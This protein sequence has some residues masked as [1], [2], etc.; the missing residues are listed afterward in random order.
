MNSVKSDIVCVE[1]LY[2]HSDN[3]E[4]PVASG[5]V[6]VA[7]SG[8]AQPFGSEYKFDDFTPNSDGA[9]VWTASDVYSTYHFFRNPGSSV[10]DTLPSATSLIAEMADSSVGTAF[11]RKYT[12]GSEYDIT[13]VM[14]AGMTAQ[15]NELT[16]YAGN[17]RDIYFVVTS[18]TTMNVWIV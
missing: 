14:G 16:V 5:A 10:N 7:A 9:T 11:K 6:Q 17:S 1:N 4:S 13:L 12:A 18:A 8:D 15:G 2:F 3:G